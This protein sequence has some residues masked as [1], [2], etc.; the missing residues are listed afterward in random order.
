MSK[1]APAPLH[2]LIILQEIS[3]MD[4]GNL[5]GNRIVIPDPDHF[6]VGSEKA[7]LLYL[8]ATQEARDS[9][10]ALVQERQKE[11]KV[12]GIWVDHARLNF[13]ILV[14]PSTTP[15]TFVSFLDARFQ[16]CRRKYSARL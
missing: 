3:N 14:L 11:C 12:E 7:L 16:N 9:I 10:L 6:Q 4:F 5:I 2:H 13:P 8:R 15:Q 1:L